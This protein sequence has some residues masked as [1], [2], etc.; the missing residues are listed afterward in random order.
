MSNWVNLAEGVNLDL[1]ETRKVGDTLG[2][3]QEGTV[4]HYKIVRINKKSGK[5][6]A[7]R[8]TLYR[9]EDVRITKK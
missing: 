9:P 1:L 7:R 8:V 5:Y 2:F 4:Q 6:W 3:M